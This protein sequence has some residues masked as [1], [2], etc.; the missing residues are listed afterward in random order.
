MTLR[1]D[2]TVLDEASE[3]AQTR[4]SEQDSREYK[5]SFSKDAVRQLP[6][7]EE[8][9]LNNDGVITKAEYNAILGKAR[10][11]D[12]AEAAARENKEREKDKEREEDKLMEELKLSQSPASQAAAPPAQTPPANDDVTDILQFDAG[13][14]FVEE[15]EGSMTMDVMRL[16]TMNGDCSV[17]YKTMDGSAVAGIRYEHVEG[18]LHFGDKE[19]CKSVTVPIIEGDTWATTLEFKIMLYDPVGC[20]LGR[21]LFVS[22]VKVIDGDSFPTNRFNKEIEERGLANLTKGEGAVNPAEV[23]IEYFKLNFAIGGVGSKT[24][25]T[26]A[27]DQMQNLYFLLTVNLLKYVADDVL[28][29]DANPETFL[30]P[31]DRQDTLFLVGALYLV[32]YAALNALDVWKSQLGLAEDSKA[33]LRENMFRKFMN[34]D[35]SSRDKVPSSERVLAMTKDTDDIVDEGYMKALEIT[36]SLGKLAVSSYFIV[37]ENPEGV[38]PIAIFAGAIF[39]FLWLKGD[40]PVKLETAISRQESAIVSTTQDSAAKYRLIADYLMR[41]LVQDKLEGNVKSLTKASIPVTTLETTN[42]YFPGWLANILT[43][44]YVIYGGE[45]VVAGR[46]QIGAFLA[47]S[48]VI[49]DVGDSF[50]DIFKSLLSMSK[51]IEPIQDIT[52]FMNLP[53]DLRAQKKINRQRRKR[54]KEERRPERLAELRRLTGVRFATDAIPIQVRDVQFQ[55][56]GTDK[57][58]IEK[59]D[60]QCPQGSLWPWWA[61]GARGS[62]PSCASWAWSWRPRTASSSC[63]RTCVSCTSPSSQSSSTPP[64]GR[65]WPLASSTGRTTTSS[66][67]ESSRSAGGLA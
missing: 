63:R 50:A 58:A 52:L 47:T 41:P 61:P 32:P 38:A 10:E 22:R 11:E 6:S 2:G 12:A 19:T 5:V 67:T 4:V 17:K 35:A 16:G 33:Y 21:Y 24:Y 29:A 66:R 23:L 64:R 9:D 46:L 28:A 3:Q 15:E 43:A 57:L 62:R 20:E 53:T 7:F 26:I 27:V 34:Y 25:A 51:A 44:G 14:Y 59:F 56:P 30:I 13:V 36:K 37:T 18:E 40:E 45:E 48:G 42:D 1:G 8:L 60:L 49:K 31:G 54:T 55:Y 65:T 39:G